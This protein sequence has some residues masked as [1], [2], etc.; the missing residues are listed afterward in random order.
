MPDDDDR[1][2]GPRTP[3]EIL[4]PDAGE[5]P[6]P[7]EMLAI[8]VQRNKAIEQMMVAAIGATR[9]DHWTD[10]DG[11]PRLTSAG[12]DVVRLRFGVSVTGKDWKRIDWEDEAGRAYQYIYTGTFRLPGGIDVLEDCVGEASSRD[13]FLGTGLDI[14]DLKREI[15]EVK[16]GDILKKA[17]SNMIQ[18]GVTELVGLRGMTWETLAKYGITPDGSQKIQYNAGAKGGG[19]GSEFTFRFGGAK[20][21]TVAEANDKDLVFYLGA[22]ERDLGDPEKKKYHASSQKAVELIKAEQARRANEKAGTVAKPNVQVTPW[23]RII[24]IGRGYGI[25]DEAIPDI[26]KGATKKTKRE[27]L[28]EADVALAEKALAAAAP[29]NDGDISY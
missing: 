18:R 14:E 3:N 24:E 19:R 28:V 15:Y 1:D 16:P 21:K 9:P 12:A 17:H 4:P 13:A 20:G 10:H 5:P 23:S 6:E 7:P 25:P 27:D 26:V 22:Y 8:V 11:K 29:R 2:G